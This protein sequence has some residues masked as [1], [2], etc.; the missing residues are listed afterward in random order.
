MLN[1]VPDSVVGEDFGVPVALTGPTSSVIDEIVRE[2]AQGMLAAAL[3]AEVAAYVA[4]FADER[5]ENGHRLVV[6][7][8]YHEPR[9]VT[10]AAAAIE[11]HA[12]RVNDKRVDPQ[13]GERVRFSSAILP[14][15]T[16]KT[17]RVEQVL[18]LLYLHGLS[19]QDFGPAMG[20]FLCSTKGLSGAT[21][22]KLTQTWQAEQKAFPARD[23]SGV[24]Y[25]YG[26]ADGMHVNVRLEE[27]KLCLL[28]LIGVRADGR[29][30]LIAL[31]DGY[32][33]AAESWADLLS[34]AAC[35]RRC[36]R[37]GMERWGFGVGCVRCSRRPAS[38]GVGSTRLRMYLP[39]CRDQRTAGRRKR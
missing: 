5:D 11:V 15:W 22:T 10:T 23:L 6:C 25:V 16:R 12:P 7:N 9:E 24:D 2:G 19:S 29:K 28:V 3:R 27:A 18:P 33:E 39:H 26:W 37:S 35:G 1:V 30:E 34:A 4:Q 20:Q 17:P 21:I 38:S 32:R 13:T 14:P 36:W 31:D 8:G